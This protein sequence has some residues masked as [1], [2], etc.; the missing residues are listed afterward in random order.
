MDNPSPSPFLVF[1]FCDRQGRL[2]RL[3][4][5]DPSEIVIAQSADQV[6]PAL[7]R[8]HQSVAAGLWAAGY[9][10]YEA[11]P[12]FDSALLVHEGARIPL[13][14]FGLFRKPVEVSSA[15]PDDGF[16]L[17]DWQPT[18]RRSRYDRNIAAVREAIERGDSYQVNYTMR[19][20]ARFEGNDFTF[21]QRLRHAQHASYCAYLNMGR[22]RILSASPELFFRWQ[23][24]QIVTR[25]MKG[26]VRRGRWA[27]EDDALAAWLAASEKN[28]AE[29]VMIV[30][31][32][33]ND[34]G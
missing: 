32:L 28:R 18:I 22:Y 1:D 25:P 23:G 10:S 12:A 29:N 6:R 31:L 16:H 19:L 3:G 15:G 9:I 4:F 26:T 14:W 34:L 24:S 30:D 11:A 2:H 13:V 21:Y 20:R 8:V 7:Q 5:R 17:S 33:R 27:E